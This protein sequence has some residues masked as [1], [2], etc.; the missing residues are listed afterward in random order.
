MSGNGVNQALSDELYS[1]LILER[2]NRRVGSI[3]RTKSEVAGIIE[4]FL[5]GTSGKWDWDDFCSFSIADPY[6]D[7]VRIRCAELDVAYPPTEKG[8]YCSR[9]GFEVMRELVAE[10]R[11][12]NQK[13]PRD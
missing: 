2:R 1:R 9:A 12:S 5:D 7:S 3:Q 10:L 8:H 13:M 4:R 6:L 11:A